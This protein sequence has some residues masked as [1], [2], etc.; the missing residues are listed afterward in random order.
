MRPAGVGWAT[1]ILVRFY[2]SGRQSY[3]SRRRASRPQINTQKQEVFS[4]KRV[5]FGELAESWQKFWRFFEKKKN[6]GDSCGP[7]GFP[8]LLH[9]ICGLEVKPNQSVTKWTLFKT[10]NE[11]K[12]TVELY[13]SLHRCHESWDLNSRRDVYLLCHRAPY[14]HPHQPQ[15]PIRHLQLQSELGAINHE[16]LL[17][18]SLPRS[19]AVKIFLLTAIKRLT[20]CPS[21]V[22]I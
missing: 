14:C 22:A 18:V 5:R 12:N 19:S 9:K 20:V 13:N 4:V 10:F 11:Y 8:Q 3:P 7:S 2:P 1:T 21:I 6:C 15:Q 17:L 16:W